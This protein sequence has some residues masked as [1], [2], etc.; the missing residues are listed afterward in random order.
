MPYGKVD[1]LVPVSDESLSKSRHSM[2]ESLFQDKIS[3]GGPDTRHS[4]L[5][6]PLDLVP[7]GLKLEPPPFQAWHLSE[8]VLEHARPYDRTKAESFLAAFSLIWL[9]SILF[10]KTVLDACP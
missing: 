1:T 8:K 7:A 10:V 9:T 4:G 3:R 2:S 5:Q 6:R